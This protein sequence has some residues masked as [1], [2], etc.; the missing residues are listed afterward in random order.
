MEMLSTLQPE[1]SSGPDKISP[2]VLR[3]AA[4][5]ISSILCQ[6]FNMS[7]CSGQIPIEWKSGRVEMLCS[8]TN[9]VA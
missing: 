1:E 7:L 2:R 6:I 9:R 5:Y 3:L 8:Y 4:P